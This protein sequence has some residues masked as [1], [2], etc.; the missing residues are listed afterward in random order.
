MS[1]NDLF[2]RDKKSKAILNLDSESLLAYKQARNEYYKIQTINKELQGVKND[3][4]EIKSLLLSL[5][6]GKNNG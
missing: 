6:N 5:I 2:A 1:N 3:V 4:A